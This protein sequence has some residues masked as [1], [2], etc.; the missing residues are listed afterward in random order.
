MRTACKHRLYLTNEQEQEQALVECRDAALAP[1]GHW[2]CAGAAP[3]P[4]AGGR[5][6]DRPTALLALRAQGAQG[7][8]V[9]PARAPRRL[10][11]ATHRHTAPQPLARHRVSQLGLIAHDRP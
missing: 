7:A 11:L 8:P 1:A 9:V 4:G 3:A 6:R 10:P 5:P 2:E